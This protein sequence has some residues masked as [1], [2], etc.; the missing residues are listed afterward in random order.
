[1]EGL[2]RSCVFKNFGEFVRMYL[3]ISACL[4]DTE[5]FAAIVVDLARKL[6]AE[7]V[8]HAEVTFT[9][10]THVNRGVAGDTLLAGLAE[11]R[12]RARPSTASSWRGCSTS[13]A[14]ASPRA[15]RRWRWRSRAARSA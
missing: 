9:P 2:R 12:A 1:M 6:A 4:T 8:R 15:R 14:T 7:N 3:A 10:M 11:G 13:S 5:D